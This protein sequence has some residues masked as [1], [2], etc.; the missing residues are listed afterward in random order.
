MAR[1]ALPQ[2]RLAP[3]LRMRRDGDR[4]PRQLAGCDPAGRLATRADGGDRSP[5]EEGHQ[6]HRVECIRACGVPRRLAGRRAGDRGHRGAVDGAVGDADPGDAVRSDARLADAAGQ[7]AGVAD[8][9]DRALHWGKAMGRAF[10]CREVVRQRVGG[11]AA[12]GAVQLGG[13]APAGG[14]S[15]NEELGRAASGGGARG[16]VRQADGVDGGIGATAGR[17]G[18]QAAGTGHF[19][20]GAGPSEGGLAA[21][22]LGPV[23]GFGGDGA[24]LEG[25]CDDMA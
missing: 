9:D 23:R 1:S 20:V 17:S 25:G 6:R 4:I 11:Y 19:Q 10:G 22:R 7:G 8:Q 12:A 16:H 15:G 13:V 5:P 24:T 3:S 21:T 2:G 18:R 14:G